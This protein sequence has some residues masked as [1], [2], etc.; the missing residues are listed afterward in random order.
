MD[1]VRKIVRDVLK[2]NTDLIN[3]RLMNV[4]DDVDYIYDTFFREDIDTLK[5]TGVITSSMFDKYAITTHILKSP[6]SQKAHAINPCEIEINS[7]NNFYSPIKSLM[8]MGITNNALNYVM[9]FDGS[10]DSASEELFNDGQA[11]ASRNIK[12]EFSESKI[13]GTI[14]HELA[15]W[16]DDTLHNQHI[17]NRAIKAS[18]FGFGMTRK[19][20]PINADK[21]EIQGQIHNI[22]QL[23]KE[24]Q[25]NW[26]SLTFDDLVGLSPTLYN[27]N[28]Q[29]SGDVKINWKR[30][31]LK[32]M[33][34]EGLLGKNM[35]KR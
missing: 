32:R 30:D 14:H 5:E 10:L 21:L 27:V 33:S 24:H 17:K 22:V 35:I 6:L 13:K 20:L 8:G 16:I 1:N 19:G 2:E 9:G 15:H 12:Y 4:D 23:K 28:N 31:L 25:Q 18:E 34:R 26:D 29:L 11:I 3:E 7:G